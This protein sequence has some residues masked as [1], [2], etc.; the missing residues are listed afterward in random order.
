MSELAQEL[1]HTFRRL[2]KSPVFTAV[3]VLTIALGIGANTAI[4]SVMNAV[5]LRSLPIPNPQQ[6]VYFHLKNQPLSTSQTG[7]GDMSMSIP[8][9]EAMRTRRDVFEE[10]IGFAPLAFEKVAVRVGR[11]PEEVLGEMV[12][13]NFFSGLGVQP[14]LGRGFTLRD[15]SAHAPVAVLNYAWWIGRFAGDKDILGKTIYVKGVPFTI[16]GVAPPGFNGI[17]PV[18][19]FMNFWVPLQNRPELNAWGTSPTDGTLYGSPNWLA[20]DM[21]GR[22]QPGILSKQAEAQLTPAFQNALARA[23]RVDPHEQKP[24]LALSSVRGAENLRDDYEDPLRFLMYMVALVLLIACANVVM[25]LLARNAGRLPEFCLRQALGAS[26]RALL[27]HLLQE[28]VVLVTAG[29]ALGWW[30][31]GAATEAITAW[32][33]VDI[34]IQPDR[35][36]LLF[37]ACVAAAVALAFGLAPMPFL[38]R[39]PL[40]LALR[41]AGGTV[42]TGRNR[43]WGRKLVVALQIS[44]CMVLLCA[45]GLL[46][47]TLRNLETSDL[48]MRT[49]GLLV[50]GV[51]PQSNIHS[52]ADAIRFHTALLER[53]RALPGVDTAT[54][55]QVRIGSGNSDNDGV[56][57]DGRNP[58]ADRPFAGVRINLVGSEFLRTLGIP[59]RLGR[60]IQDSDTPSSPKVAI[61]NQTFVDRYLPGTDPLGHHIAVLGDPKVPYTIVGVAGNSRYT[62]VRETDRP[63][64]YLPFMQP[65][66]VLGMQYEVHTAGDPKMLIKEA[67]KLVHDV[68]PNLPLE[69]PITQ[70][71][72]FAETVA[73]ERLIANLS[74]FFAGLAGF[75]VAIGLYGTISYSIGRR[76]MEIGVRLALGAQRHEV[77]WMVLVESFSVTALG[78]TLGIPA[79]LAVARTLRSMMYG[80]SPSDPLT[81]LLALACIAAVTLAAAI[82]PARRAASLD[83]MRALQME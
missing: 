45:A 62:E 46:Y 40:N 82:F 13:G 68:D 5:L 47:R 52:N 3:A 48:G 76:T 24:L 77:L 33:G 22:L 8:V 57:V 74:V 14:G 12:S 58:A 72:Q 49:A 4:F 54:I 31:A 64:A 73:Q 63:M 69:K 71:D 36:V 44:L 20:L 34:L 19:H 29:A 6:L 27:L 53:M 25:L 42:S 11:E 16:V 61:V 70:Q 55:M 78:L 35:R 18:H 15:E 67:E 17:D 80:L 60:D 66:G 65:Q 38:R 43:F 7:Y 39:L 79:S 9:F 30:F 50:F 1:R 10:V 23:S 37:T 83:P 51:S 21:L 2:A 41:S 75:L 26:G 59:L 28:S 32:S 56:F 81:V